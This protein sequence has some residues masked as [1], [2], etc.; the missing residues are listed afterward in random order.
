MLLGMIVAITGKRR[1]LLLY[2]VL[3]VI[4]GALALYDFYMWEYRYGHNLN[5]EAPIQVPGMSY[6]PLLFGHKR[7]LN[8]DLAYSFPDV[9]GWV[10]M[11]AAAL[12]FAVWF[13]EW[14]KQR[15]SSRKKIP[16]AALLIPV[17]FFLPVL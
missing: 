7:L 16:V 3:T 5:P 6:Q 15:K 4:G 10:V 11:G 1:F 14:Y 2:L 8:F 17:L 9:G 12:A 13:F